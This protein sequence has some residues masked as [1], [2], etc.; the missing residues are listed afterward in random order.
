MQATNRIVFNTVVLYA[1]IAISMVISLYTVPLVLHALGESDYGLFNLIS[2]LIAMLAFMNGAMTLSTQRYLSVTIGELNTDKLLQVYNL[3]L[4]LHFVLGF[5]VVIAMELLAPYL[6]EHVLN[7][8]PGQKDVAYLLFHCMAASMFF[9]IVSVPF[10]AIINAY[11]NMLF[12]SI[13]GILEAVLRL[14]LALSLACL[15]SQRLAVYGLCLACISL[16]ILIVKYIYCHRK[17]H[18]LYLSTRYWKNHRLM[19]EMFIYAG[20]NTLSALAVVGRVQGLAIILNHFFSTILNAAYG[21]ANQVNGVLSYFSATI[22]KSINPQL[23]ENEGRHNADRQTTLAYAL[24]KYSLL[25]LGVLA[26]PLAI[27][28]PYIYKIWLG[29]VP[30]NSIAFTRAII[31]LSLISQTSAGLMSAIQSSGHI[32]WYTISICT[33]LLSTLPI[34]YI[35]LNQG[36]SPVWALWLACFTEVGA[37]VIRLIFAHR[38]KSIHIGDYLLKAVLPNL[39]LILFVG[40]VLYMLT[41]IIPSSMA[42]LIIVIF[43]DALLFLVLA[44]HIILTP[45]ERIYIRSL[46]YKIR[47]RHET[48]AK[49]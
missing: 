27:E 16:F 12:F 14:A 22:Q 45:S 24:T 5:V 33:T 2:G 25:I 29:A 35:F 49:E 34:A 13:V 36:L 28:L 30:A 31:T 47:R 15:T 8:L 11:E 18:H 48:M 20:W 4:L 46:I 1:K 19:S 7:I 40:A 42:R 17:Y 10:D 43:T 37:V 26:L 3:S 38:L 39:L 9:T 44:Y 23:M 6:L 41:Q 21:I 32:K